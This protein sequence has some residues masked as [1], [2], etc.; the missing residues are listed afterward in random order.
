MEKNKDKNNFGKDLIK[1]KDLI[2]KDLSEKLR[3]NLFFEYIV[4]KNFLEKIWYGNQENIENDFEKVEGEEDLENGFLV[5]GNY[6]L[7][8]KFVNFL[9]R[10]KEIQLEN[11]EEEDLYK[12]LSE[13][14]LEYQNVN[15]F[16]Y[17]DWFT[18][19]ENG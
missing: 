10:C 12:E 1:E 16:D 13:Q 4:N 8:K 15:L 14:E 2:E 18:G 6:E 17:F 3:A 19:N 7:E 5:W 9:K 11:E